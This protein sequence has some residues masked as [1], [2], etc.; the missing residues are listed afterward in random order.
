MHQILKKDH[1]EVFAGIARKQRIILVQVGRAFVE[2]E[3][4][5]SFFC[6]SQCAAT[7]WSVVP[8]I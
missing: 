6:L 4:E 1:V 5:G 7:S 3:S 2:G 8:A